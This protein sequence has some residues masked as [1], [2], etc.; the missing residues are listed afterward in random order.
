[1]MVLLR[2]ERRMG[3]EE[4]SLWRFMLAWRNRES[5]WDLTEKFGE[6]ARLANELCTLLCVEI[7]SCRW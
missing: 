6:L 7:I 2:M 1:M 4:W 5:V 3:G